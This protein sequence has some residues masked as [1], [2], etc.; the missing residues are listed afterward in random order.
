MRSLMRSKAARPVVSPKV[1]TKSARA[2]DASAPTAAP[3]DNNARATGERGTCVAYKGA[4]SDVNNVRTSA[5]V[6]LRSALERIPDRLG[7]LWW[8]SPDMGERR[9]VSKVHGTSKERVERHQDTFHPSGKH[10]G[11]C[12]LQGRKDVHWHI[13]MIQEN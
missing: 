1:A 12:T 11:R 5:R 6:G 10:E 9:S 8:E 3:A 2:G 4:C 13:C 7:E